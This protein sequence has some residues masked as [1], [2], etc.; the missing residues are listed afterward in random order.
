MGTDFSEPDYRL[1][2]IPLRFN[3]RRTV[4]AG[5]ME[6][7]FARSI[8]LNAPTAA[9]LIDRQ[10][11]IR[12]ANPAAYALLGDALT[13]PET[14]SVASLVEGLGLNGDST[15]AEVRAFNDGN[16]D[17][18]D[19][20][21]R[22]ARRLNGTFVPVDL[23]AARLSAGGEA[24]VTLFIEDRTKLVAAETALQEL[25][26]RMTQ[27][28]RLN[29]LGEMVSVLAHELSQP[30]SAIANTV[31]GARHLM[32]QEGFQIDCGVKAAEATEVE[33]LRAIDVIRRLKAILARDKG[34]HDSAHVAEVIGEILPILEI[35]ARELDADLV[36]DVAPDD[37]T[38]CDRVQLQQLVVNLV[39][40][41]MEAPANGVR[42]QVRISG[43][44]LGSG[45][46][47]ITVEDNGPGI[48][49]EVEQRLFDPLVSTK[50]DG[51]GLGLS[52]CRTIVEAHR[53][54]IRSATS[55]LGGAAFIVSLNDAGAAD[56]E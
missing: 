38:A 33:A 3:D 41:A 46:Y 18:G 48:A 2:Q 44:S 56:H 26:V 35:R 16:L 25:R 52:I 24:F 45:A 15:E 4:G 17:P 55:A 5:N 50:A 11:H 54:R 47:T 29:S 22:L 51:M 20:V 37:Q 10:G 21:H 28:W 39:R 27:N 30:L 53:G 7:A 43:R 13:G 8:L 32:A 42:R 6:G 14:V 36:L 12:C 40:N 31:H 9:I 34:Y 49:A 19:G 1:I 23:H